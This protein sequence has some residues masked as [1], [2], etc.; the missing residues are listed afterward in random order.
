MN[1]TFI[2]CFIICQFTLILT[3]ISIITFGIVNIESNN[4]RQCLITLLMMWVSFTM[5]ISFGGAVWWCT[6]PED[7]AIMDEK[8]ENDDLGKD[9]V[10]CESTRRE[11]F[12]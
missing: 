2:K 8:D 10:S 6:T 3:A 5:M 12:V 1:L 7:A 9:V 4:A 11:Q